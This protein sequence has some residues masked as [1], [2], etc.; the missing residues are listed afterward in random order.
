MCACA[1]SGIL[2]RGT[3]CPYG[4]VCVPLKDVK[5]GKTL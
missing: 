3:M 5:T 4:L 2:E 1:D